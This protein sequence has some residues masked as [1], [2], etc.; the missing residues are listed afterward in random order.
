MDEILSDQDSTNQDSVND[1]IEAV[2]SPDIEADIEASP[3][4]EL[5][6]PSQTER[7]HYFINEIVEDLLREY[8]WTS[9]TDVSLRDQI[10]GHAPELITQIIRKQN[11]HM[12]YPG[13]E[14]SAFGDLT[15]TAW[16]VTPDTMVLSHHG[17]STVDDVAGPESIGDC[18]A[19]LYGINGFDI[20][21]GYTRRPPSDTLLVTTKYGYN[22][23]ATL[24]HPFL[25]LRNNGAEWVNSGDLKVGDLLA[26]QYGQMHFGCDN[27]ILFSPTRTSGDIKLW[28]PPSEFT[29]DLAYIIGL[30]ISEGSIEPGRVVVYNN[31]IEVINKLQNND[32]GL[33]FKLESPGRSVYNGVRFI[34]FLSWLG[35]GPGTRSY[36]KHIPA[37]IMKCS[38]PIISALLRGMFDGD[39][40]ST[41]HNGTVGYTSCSKLLVNQL[42]VILL[43][44]GMLSKT[45]IS[46]RKPAIVL[47]NKK[48]SIFRTS[49]QLCMSTTDSARFYDMIG[50]LANRK[51][52]KRASLS[53]KPF[54]LVDEISTAALQQAIRNLPKKIL[55]QFGYDKHLLLRKKQFTTSLF[56]RLV[57]GLALDQS[58]TFLHDR[59]IEYGGDDRSEVKVMWLPITSIISA[60]R[61]PTIGFCLPET[62]TF[63]TNGI[64]SHNTQ[65]ER[66]LYKFRAKPHCRRC[67]NPERPNDSM[68]YSPGENEYGIITYDRLFEL[69]GR[70]CPHC[71]AILDSKPRIEPR[72]GMFGGSESILFKGNSKVFNMWS[73]IART[74]I[75]AFVKKEGRDRKNAN[76]Y[77]DHLCVNPKVDEDRLKR[78]FSEVREICK[79]NNDHLRCLEALVQIVRTDDKPYDGLIGKLVEQSGLSRPQVALF[80]KILRLRSAEFSDS[81]LNREGHRGDHQDHRKPGPGDSAD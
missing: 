13:Q 39:G 80:I 69:I 23:Q 31:E 79:H 33:Q 6:D 21:T 20:A 57:Y 8:L 15:H 40:H 60:G 61:S 65:I 5:D 38:Q 77:R 73:Q 26:V 67:Y 34:E 37:R 54:R 9:C 41:R 7:R 78:F 63:T 74:V 68:L 49:Y 4:I 27:A 28:N 30:I 14:D 10:M 72:Q 64:I 19:R 18:H 43:N 32:C 47:N 17:L 70:S 52:I 62:K 76:Q 55:W 29:E 22:V 56:C 2:P 66:T 24:D 3:D 48:P 42:R 81:P 58:I 51:A 16:C 12:I 25:V 59:V 36:S 45:S 75:L 44:Y 53:S 1:N 71:G 46:N 50:F 11:L 35:L